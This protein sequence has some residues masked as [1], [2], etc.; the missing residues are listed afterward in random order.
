VCSR[1]SFFRGAVG[2]RFHHKE[3]KR[4]RSGFPPASPVP[5]RWQGIR[6]A[7]GHNQSQRMTRRVPRFLNFL[8]QRIPLRQVAV[9]VRRTKKIRGVSDRGAT[10][11][12]PIR[13]TRNPI[14]RL[15]VSARNGLASVRCAKSAERFRQSARRSRHLLATKFFPSKFFHGISRWMRA[16][17]G[18][19]LAPIEPIFSPGDYRERGQLYLS[20]TIQTQHDKT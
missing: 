18:K 7:G 14:S 10:T 13:Q 9:S 1:R 19:V 6:R 17:C 3:I 8:R 5:A 12:R 2:G 4:R 20:S 16:A 15:C 11:Q